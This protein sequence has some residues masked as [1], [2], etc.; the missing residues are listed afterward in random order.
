MHE[1]TQSYHHAR[2][3][4][5][6]R[7]Q[8]ELFLNF[9]FPPK[10]WKIIISRQFLKDYISKIPGNKLQKKRDCK[11]IEL[12][13]CILD[14][15]VILATTTGGIVRHLD[16]C[17]AYMSYCCFFNKLKLQVRFGTHCSTECAQSSCNNSNT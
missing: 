13:W 11:G 9:L 5:M 8:N 17:F 3:R 1:H 4:G 12:N 16:S 10:I 6:K 7:C 2:K 15:W 14:C